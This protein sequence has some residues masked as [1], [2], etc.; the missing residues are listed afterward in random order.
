MVIKDEDELEKKGKC[1]KDIKG[2]G[3]EGERRA[4]VGVI[5]EE[6]ENRKI[7][8]KDWKTVGKVTD[9]VKEKV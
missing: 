5:K 6:R 1:N 4:K 2:W 7:E 9:K 3:R 8:E